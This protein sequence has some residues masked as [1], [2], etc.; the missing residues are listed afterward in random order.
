[1]QYVQ[2]GLHEKF[3]SYLEGSDSLSSYIGFTDQEPNRILACQ[4][5]VAL[6]LATLDLS[7]ASD[8]VSNQHV[9]DLFGTRRF[10]SGAIQSCRSQ[11]ADVPGHGITTLSKFASMGSA[12]TF[13]VEAMV[14]LTIIFIGIERELN[15]QLT[16]EL[17]NEL[18]GQVRV[19]GDDIIVP[20]R[21]VRSVV[22]AL[23]DFGLLV[24]RNKSFWT[25]KFRE[26]CGG[27]FYDGA[28]VNVVRAKTGI[29][30]Q[31]KHATEIISTVALRNQFYFTGYWRTAEYL[32]DLLRRLIPFPTVHPFSPGLGRHSL[33]DY[34]V[35]KECPHLQRPLV[36]AAVTDTRIPKS[37][38]SD[39]GALLK[40][41]LK[42][43]DEPLDKNHLE[44][45]G[46]PDAVNIK[47][48]WI[49]PF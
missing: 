33:L 18:K 15:T 38:L 4:G 26:S 43:G 36:K 23:E 25:G 47:L 49:P 44:R 42:R 12:L 14:F 7:E 41:F 6:D 37:N 13:P 34:E 39:S 1:M 28:D 17:I 45:A 29:P 3:V 27:D 9:C 24:N 2:Q 5:S 16:R 20:V 32:D 30:S 10:L 46:R 31:R 35:Q 21:Y 40:F 19:Y 48:R 22:D 11:K 8:R